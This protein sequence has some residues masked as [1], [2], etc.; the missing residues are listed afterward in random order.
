MV[1]E[2]ENDEDLD[3]YVEGQESGNSGPTREESQPL[4]KKT[5]QEYEYTARGKTIKEP[6]D[7]ILKRASQGYDYSQLMQDFNKKSFD[8]D[9]RFKQF[10]GRSKEFDQRYGHYTKIDE[11]AQQNPQQWQ[12]LLQQY[13]SQFGGNQQQQNFQNNQNQFQQTQVNPEIEQLKNKLNEFESFKNERLSKEQT[14]QMAVEDDK[15]NKDVES[16]RKEY[17]YLDFDTPDDSGKSLYYKIL[18]H[19]QEINTSNFRVAFRDFNHDNLLKLAEDKGKESIAKDMEKKTKLGLVGKKNQPPGQKNFSPK[20]IRSMSY[21]D[22]DREARKA[23]GV[24]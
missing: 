18:A 11:W 9:N 23:F 2:F 17:S 15:F 6:I 5:A 4:D 24:S 13:Q 16:I 14:E 7:Q 22:V 10:E 20:E 21:D 19:A 3:A 1:T 8:F 12:Y